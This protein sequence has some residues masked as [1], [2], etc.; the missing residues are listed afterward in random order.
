MTETPLS[1]FLVQ[2]N[3]V[4]AK[5]LKVELGKRLDRVRIT[6]N[7][8]DY[9]N[10]VPKLPFPLSVPHFVIFVQASPPSSGNGG[11]GPQN[12]EVCMLKDYRELDERSRDVLEEVLQRIYF[13]PRVLKVEKLE[14]SGDE[15]EW[16]ILTDRG[17][18][19]LHTRGRR[20]VISM[21]A[22]I[23]IIDTH[24]NIYQVEDVRKL[25]GK[26]RMLLETVA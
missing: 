17:R 10:V 15:F 21:G 25:D 23:I 12:Q 7:G 22:R 20:N 6:V 2:L 11:D 5:D 3:L 14:T 16:E 13:I 4:Q 1:D 18:R 19:T 26:S 8:L 24:E 9:D